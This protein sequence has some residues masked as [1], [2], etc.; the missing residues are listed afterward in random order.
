MA[1][2]AL[3]TQ[4][5]IL[6][7]WRPLD[8][9][10]MAAI[11][12]NS[13]VTEFLNRPMD[14]T[15]VAAFCDLMIGHWASYGFGPW[16]VELRTAGG[17]GP[18]LGFAGLAQLPPYLSAAGSG[19]ELG[20]RLARTVW[21][22]GYATEAAQAARDHAITALGLK[23]LVSVIHPDNYRSRRVAAKLGMKEWRKIENPILGLP[24]DL[25]RFDA[26]GSSALPAG[27]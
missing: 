9:A 17:E 2:D 6:R 14:E 20:W 24:V 10:P 25:W 5:L 15:G 12:R 22:K 1:D 4:R 27:G 16:A 11:N 3:R 18:L 13:E 8:A 19:P 7:R 23:Q 26:H 21:G